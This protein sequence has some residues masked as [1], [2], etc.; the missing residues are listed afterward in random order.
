MHVY[1]VSCYASLYIALSIVYC[2]VEFYGK[3]LIIP[4]G[5]SGVCTL[6]LEMATIQLKP[7]EPF[8]FKTPDEWPRW[9]RCFEQFRVASG[10]AE[11]SA[12]KQVSTLLY[13]LGE[14]VE[15]VLTS[16]NATEEE[17]KKYDTVIEKFDAFFQVRRN[18]IFEWARFN[19]RNQLAGES[20]EQ[21][22]MVLYSLAAHCNY[23]TMESEMIRD[24]LVIGI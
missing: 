6:A 11:V 21:Y 17:H 9:H 4:H 13:C 10:L 3:I 1:M 8:N 24:R 5:G 19:R 20:A 15:S 7:P 16:T 18:I 22:I 14:E 2:T 12:T 23:G